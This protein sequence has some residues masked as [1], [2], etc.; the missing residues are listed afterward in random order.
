M[1]SFIDSADTNEIKELA[2]TGLVDGV[3]TN[4]SLIA[5]SGRKMK[6]VIKEK[7]FDNLVINAGSGVTG[8][9][10]LKG[11]MDYDNFIPQKNSYL[12]TTAGEKS[13]TRMLKKW[14]VYHHSNIH[15]HAASCR[16]SP[17]TSRPRP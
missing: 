15:I 8:S 12:I 17:G 9:G 2:D 14:D 1:K 3:T 13:I 6:E 7:D 11:F 16:S 4:P 5:K 10:L